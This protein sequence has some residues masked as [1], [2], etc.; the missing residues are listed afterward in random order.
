MLAV[1]LSL[2]DEELMWG[3]FANA[4][5]TADLIRS[6]SLR[7]RLDAEQLSCENLSAEVHHLEERNQALTETLREV[8]KYSRKGTSKW[9]LR[10]E[11]R[12]NALLAEQP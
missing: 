1:D 9:A 2:I 3:W 11:E 12:I 5:E 7:E 4:I 10:I 8:Q 6:K